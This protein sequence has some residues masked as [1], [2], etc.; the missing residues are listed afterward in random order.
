MTAQDLYDYMKDALNAFGLE[1]SEKYQLDVLLQGSHI[2]FKYGMREFHVD[3]E[4]NG[5]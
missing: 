4:Y 1:W 5:E 3:T 2:I